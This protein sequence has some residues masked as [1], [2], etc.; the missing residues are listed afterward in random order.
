[1][2][3]LVAVLT[4]GFGAVVPRQAS[5]AASAG[6]TVAAEVGDLKNVLEK[7]L[8]ARRPQE[9]EFVDVVVTMVGNDTLPLDLVRSTF[10]W[11]RKK[12]KTTPY[13]FPYFERGLRVR[14]ARMGIKIPEID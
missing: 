11:A 4:V 14:A 2:A 5:P 3:L 12:A 6:G 1:M 13:P 9:F 10:L 7:G 8:R